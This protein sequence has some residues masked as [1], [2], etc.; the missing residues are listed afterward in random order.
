[1][2][3]ALQREAVARMLA[4]WEQAAPGRIESIF[5]AIKSVAPSQ[6]ADPELFDF[7]GLEARRALLARDLSDDEVEAEI[8]G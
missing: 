1:M 2:V 7:A 3:P 6:L 8:D 4:D 5:T